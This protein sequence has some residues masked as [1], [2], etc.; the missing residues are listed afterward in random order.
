MNQLRQ[1]MG[2]SQIRF[3]CY[4]K[5][6]GKTLHIMTK[7]TPEGELVIR[8]FTNSTLRPAACGSFT[9]LP[10]DN[11]TVSQQCSQWGLDT[12]MNPDAKWG[13][14]RSIVKDRLH[15][16][17]IWSRLGSKHVLQTKPIRSLLYCDDHWDYKIQHSAGDF[18]L[19]FVR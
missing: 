19:I 10:D 11:S 17:P 5:L 2:F 18:W 15:M 16:E 4:E 13:A 9:A 1:D 14:S 12:R 6:V 3:Y 7:D 8:Y